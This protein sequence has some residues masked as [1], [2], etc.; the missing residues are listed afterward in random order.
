MWDTKYTDF[1]IMNTPYKKDVIKMLADECHK[2]GILLSF[3]YSCPDWHHEHGF[4]KASTHQW[5]SPNKENANQEIYREYVKNQI[6][7]L[8]TNYGKIYTLFW[9]ISP[10]VIDPSINELVRKLQ[11]GI[12]IN[13]RGW[14]KG[15][16]STPEREMDEVAADVRFSS[17]TEMCEA[18]GE[19]SWG[20]RKNE[21]YQSIRYLTHSI[22]KIMAKGGNYL[23]N[24]G[25]KADGT[26]PDEAIAVIKKVGSWYNR[27]EGSL[28]CTETD[29]FD[30]KIKRYKCVVNKKN[31]K[32]YFN[33]YEGIL[34][35]SVNLGAYPNAPKR[36]R[37]MNTGKELPHKIEVLHDYFDF[38]TGKCDGKYLHIYDIP[39][40]EYLHEPIVIEI[41][42]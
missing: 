4:N 19:Q 10:R 38:D 39:V 32:S 27:M 9:D 42:W 36:V 13:N 2:Q 11:P 3:Y 1:N 24:V 41:E 29:T 40:D 25:P 7:E 8:L 26:I 5:K 15:D 16:F 28:E 17:M 30:Y 14:D 22:D 12:Y 34:S 31:G 18:V 21:D 33:F 20:Y 6:T 23:L 37:L 35:S